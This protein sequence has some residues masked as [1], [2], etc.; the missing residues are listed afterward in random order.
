MNQRRR[1]RHAGRG[2]ELA[3]A[4]HDV[5]QAI[6]WWVARIGDYVLD[7]QRIALI[8]LGVGAN[9]SM[10]AA[11]KHNRALCRLISIYGFYD[12]ARPQGVLSWLFRRYAVKTSSIA[13]VSPIEHAHELSM[14]VTILHGAKDR[15]SPIAYARAF[16]ERREHHKLTTDLQVYGNLGH[17]F[18]EL[19]G[20]PQCL[21]AIEAI[22]AALESHRSS[23]D[24]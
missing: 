11:R 9:V 17:G 19:S 20:N 15:L 23:L 5:E 6:E 12:W 8:G 13:E 18:L 21:S 14:P 7:A 22:L 3:T 24:W 10:L 2:G 4:A 16:H 1:F